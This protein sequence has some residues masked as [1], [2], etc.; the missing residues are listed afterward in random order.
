[1]VVM[2]S[3]GLVYKHHPLHFHSQQ[4]WPFP[5]NFHLWASLQYPPF[6]CIYLEK[7]KD[8]TQWALLKHHWPVSQNANCIAD[9]EGW[10]EMSKRLPSSCQYDNR[11]QEKRSDLHKL[12]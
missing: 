10:K 6:A 1:M 3:L 2:L 5:S 12:I 11:S 7:M 9:R 4:S 8:K